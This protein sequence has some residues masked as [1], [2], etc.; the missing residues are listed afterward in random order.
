MIDGYKAFNENRTNN[1]G[2]IFKENEIYSTSKNIKFGLK[3]EGYHFAKNIED[4]FRYINDKKHIEIA[5]VTALGN[6]I[7]VNDE[8]Y[9][10]YDL[11]VTN[12]LKVDKFWTRE[13]ILSLIISKGENAICRFII[14]GFKLTEKELEI[15]YEL[16]NETV[17]K[18]IE[19]YYKNNKDVF[20]KQYI[21]EKT[22]QRR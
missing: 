12:I 20:R 5:K 22:L 16:N 14:T 6:V 21:K 19:F 18:Y 1:Y 4:T 15:L 8:F 17:D 2:M 3:G 10:Y 9:G 7:T 13:E 11:Y